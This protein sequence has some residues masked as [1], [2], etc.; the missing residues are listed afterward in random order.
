MNELDALRL[1]GLKLLTGF[2]WVL[3]VGT[4][5]RLDPSRQWHFTLFALAA[6]LGPTYASVRGIYDLRARLLVAV[7]VPAYTIVGLAISTASSWTIDSYMFFYSSIAL[8]AIMGDWRPVITASAAVALHL[9]VLDLVTPQDIFGG[10]GDLGRLALHEGVVIMEAAGLCFVTVQLERLFVRQEAS[11]RER[12]RMQAEAVAERERIARDAQAERD[13]LEAAARA[14]REARESEQ[15]QVIEALARGLEALAAGDL[16]HQIASSF[17]IAYEELRSHFNASA[18]DLDAAFDAVT[19]AARHINVSTAEIRT[20]AD[21][22][23]GR[24]EKQA[25]ALEHTAASLNNVTA[26][27]GETA[28]AASTLKDS[29]GNA[30]L[31]AAKGGEV[32]RR[33]ISAM[34][35]IQRS[36]SQIAKI[37]TIIDGIAFQTNL[38]ALNAGV[39][40]ARA[41]EAGKGFAVV[42]TEVRALAQRSAEAAKDIKELIET[43]VGQ[44]NE[45]VGLVCDT[46]NVLET[47]VK[48]VT[49]FGRSVDSIAETAKRQASDLSHVNTTISAVEIST[50]QNAAMVEESTAALRNLSD[51]VRQMVETVNR[52]RGGQQ[53]PGSS[54]LRAA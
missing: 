43:S 17:P 48:Q 20:A 18:R 54:Q 12:E 45:G 11:H 19:N 49:D 51:E 2:C 42:A 38:L 35:L 25:A 21:D 26:I 31:Q 47:V 24:T 22:L 1:R 30:Q 8:I 29:I 9:V 34:E 39:E 53:R 10:N 16:S 14:E 7:T 5:A 40:A 3:S 36:A 27:V 13:R 15:K 52:F 41:G 23:A 50:Q 37:V 44:V 28:G 32:V 33:A 4:L 6:P 46:G